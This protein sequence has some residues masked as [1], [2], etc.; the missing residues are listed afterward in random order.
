MGLFVSKDIEV[1]NNFS[2]SGSS[3]LIIAG[4]GN[5]GKQYALTRHNTGFICLDG[6]QAAQSEF[7]PWIEKKNLKSHLSSGTFGSIKVILVKPTTFMNGSG[8]AIR[9]VLDYYKLSESKLTVVHDELDLAFG[10][11]RTRV[12]GSS[13]GH[14]G[15]KSLV[16]H[17]GDNFG[18]VRVGINNADKPEAIDSADYVLAKFGKDEQSHLKQMEREVQ[19]LLI[20]LIYRGE[21]YPDTRNFLL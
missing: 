21:L 19:S 18:R 8:Q 9:A 6:L 20:E 10:Q 7:E 14:N 3:T 4:L 13:A 17:I 5:P 11:I 15:I 16:S 1:N 12:G 2:L